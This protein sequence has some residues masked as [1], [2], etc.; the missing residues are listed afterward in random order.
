[1]MISPVLVWG[2]G[3]LGPIGISVGS[4]R[5]ARGIDMCLGALGDCLCTCNEPRM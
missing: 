4:A 3:G 2:I 5:K 1:M